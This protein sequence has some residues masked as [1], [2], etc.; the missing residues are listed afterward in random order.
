MR[1]LLA[2]LDAALKRRGTRFAI[3]ALVLALHGA[4]VLRN[5]PV[6]P[7]LRGEPLASVELAFHSAGAIEGKDFLAEL[8]RIWG[9]SPR[10]M[11][12][13]PFGSWN[14]IGTRGYEFS[15]AVFPFC[16][17]VTAFW[18]WIVLTAFLPP[19]L[20]AW[21]C[22]IATRDGITSS[23][24]LW[25]SIA[26]YQLGN[27]LGYFW[28]SGMIAFVM[29]SALAV[30]FTAA[31][32]R[33]VE[34]GRWRWPLL[35]G[36]AVAGIMWINTLAMVAVAFGALFVVAASWRTAFKPRT[37]VRLAIPFLVG[38]DLGSAVAVGSVAL[39]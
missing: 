23:V 13:Y 28:S 34:D 12:G 11:A 16:S 1:E 33:S 7:I 9:Y 14:S 4:L 6:G 22:R 30:L 32:H 19:V 35:G 26:V 2:R 39:S 15:S 20:C 29:A 31:Y 18:L 10:Y 25:G 37:I 24:C 21:A 36:G 8:H 38:I 5:F 3:S 27:I 17:Q